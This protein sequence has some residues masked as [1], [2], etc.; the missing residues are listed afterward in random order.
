MMGPWLY[1]IRPH[2]ADRNYGSP[3]GN[4][5]RS[6][7][8][9]TVDSTAKPICECRSADDENKK[10][11]PRRGMTGPKLATAPVAVFA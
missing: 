7:W 5:R 2:A 9:D 11:R 8:F 3:A 10:T 1:V 6:R 4:G